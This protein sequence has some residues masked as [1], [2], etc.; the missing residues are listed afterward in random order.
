MSEKI[1]GFNLILEHPITDEEAFKFVEALTNFKN[2]LDAKPLPINFFEYEC[3]KSRIRH[4]MFMKMA[5]IV[6]NQC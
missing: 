2:V 5:D 1:H 4:E 6:K 3:A